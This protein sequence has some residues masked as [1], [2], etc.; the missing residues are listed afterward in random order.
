MSF[1]ARYAVIVVGGYDKHDNDDTSRVEILQDNKDA[2]C[3]VPHFPMKTGTGPVMFQHKKIIYL[4]GGYPTNRECWKLVDKKWVLSSNKL[5]RD[6]RE[7]TSVTMNNGIYILG[8]N[9]YNSNNSNSSEFLSKDSD[10]WV[11]GPPLGFASFRNCAVKITE[12]TLVLIGRRNYKNIRAYA[13]L[14]TTSKEWSNKGVLGAPPT[15]PR[16]RH[17]CD[18][19]NKKIIVTGGR[20]LGPDDTEKTTDII[21]ISQTQWQYRRGGNMTFGRFSHGMAIIDLDGKSTLCVF[22]GESDI[23]EIWDDKSET[24]STTNKLRFFERRDFGYVTVEKEVLNC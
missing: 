3:H 17:K 7:A 18:V 4:C 12:D 1:S 11:N 22:G 5:K 16:S 13:L 19:F 14:N 10:H 20:G 24:W 8:S 6:R 2:N 9:T 23:V 15:Y 21:D